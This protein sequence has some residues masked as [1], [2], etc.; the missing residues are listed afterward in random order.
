MSSLYTLM[1][2]L[3]LVYLVQ[4]VSCLGWLAHSEGDNQHVRKAKYYQLAK[5]KEQ[6]DGSGGAQFVS[7]DYY[8]D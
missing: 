7:T 8:T 1:M 2:I 5:S 4:V 6:P 3:V